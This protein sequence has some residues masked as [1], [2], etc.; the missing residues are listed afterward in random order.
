MSKKYSWL[1]TPE[2]LP[3]RKFS[4]FYT[5]SLPPLSP[6]TPHPI[7]QLLLYPDL[8]SL[9]YI[10]RSH[11]ICA[12]PIYVNMQVYKS[13]SCIQMYHSLSSLTLHGLTKVCCKLWQ[14]SDIINLNEVPWFLNGH[15]TYNCTCT[16]Q[17]QTKHIQS[18]FN[19][20]IKWFEYA[21][22]TMKIRDDLLKVIWRSW[23]AVTSWQTSE[24]TLW[25][26]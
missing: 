16:D 20:T 11:S 25:C 9:I 24:G 14:R 22:K 3:W 1:T 26:S 6:T 19:C 13:W 10:W 2:L 8:Y 7:H 18:L 5:P 23:R 15:I 17:S 12:C 21:S 4:T